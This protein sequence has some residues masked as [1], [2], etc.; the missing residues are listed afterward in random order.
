MAGRVRRAEKIAKARKCENAKG[1]CMSQDAP[2]RS[3]L[4]RAGGDTG[5][6]DWRP[7]RLTLSARRGGCMR[8]LSC[9][10]RAIRGLRHGLVP[11]VN[12]V[13]AVSKGGAKANQATSPRT[14][15]ATPRSCGPRQIE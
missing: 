14:D 1:A 10:L 13:G 4:R 9:V 3:W 11:H 6:W 8:V 7:A 5:G 12:D 2:R 15:S